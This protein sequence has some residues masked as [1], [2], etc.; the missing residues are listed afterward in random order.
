ML[1]YFDRYVAAGLRPIA[2][3]RDSKRPVGEGWNKDW[4]VE[5]WRGY[6]RTGGY[7]MGILLGDIIDVEG[8][9]PEANDLLERMIDGLPHPM[10]RSCKSVHHLFLSPDPDL[11]RFVCN[12]IEF[13]GRLH[14]SVLPPSVH[15]SGVPYRW[16]RDSR[17]P[18]P[19]LPDELLKFYFDNR[20]EKKER[21]VPA[22]SRP[23]TKKGHAR[24]QCRVCQGWFYI[25]KKRLVLEVRSF[26]EHY[27]LPWMCHGCRELD[28]RGLC[29]RMRREM[30]R[31]ER[32]RSL[33]VAPTELVPAGLLLD[34][35]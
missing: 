19:T 25:H 29:R 5:R 7:N 35:F 23:R 18:I 8:D 30:K 9:T 10:F 13:R 6:F 24:T 16:L 27:G 21:P 28:M 31:Q 26:R 33:N 14:Q 22:R 20:R 1:E 2:V 4:K 32:G 34:S 11:T 17:F 15:E 12:G 3:Y